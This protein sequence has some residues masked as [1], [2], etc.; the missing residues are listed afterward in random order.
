MRAFVAKVSE[1]DWVGCVG[2]GAGA[3][4]GAEGEEAGADEKGFA[5][6]DAEPPV[7]NGLMVAEEEVGGLTPKRD[8]PRLVFGAA[9]A[10]VSC[11]VCS[12]LGCFDFSDSAEMAEAR[13]AL[14][15]LTLPSFLLQAFLLHAHRYSR[16][17]WPG[18]RSGRSPLSWRSRVRRLLQFLH[19]ARSPGGAVLSSSHVYAVCVSKWFIRLAGLCSVRGVR[20][21]GW[22]CRLLHPLSHSRVAHWSR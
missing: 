15:A 5:G 19:L 1:R 21:T 9:G 22:S 4:V 13:M 17:S 12:F 2:A 11:G 3:G 20:P 14:K 18:K 8:S 6:R 16:R 10:G 7:E